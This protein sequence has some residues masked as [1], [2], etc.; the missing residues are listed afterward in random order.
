[1]KIKDDIDLTQIITALA[2]IGSMVAWG[3]K[4][5]RR[6]SENAAAYEAFETV[7]E[8]RWTESNRRM[9]SLRK[10]ITIVEQ[11]LREITP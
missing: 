4:L 5:E 1:M 10:D 2:F 3:M 8:V 11:Q 9:E 7:Q 6:V